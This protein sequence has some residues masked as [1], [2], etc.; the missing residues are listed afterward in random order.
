MKVREAIRRIRKGNSGENPA[1]DALIQASERQAPIKFAERAAW[2]EANA[3]LSAYGP[4]YCSRNYEFNHREELALQKFTVEYRKRQPLWHPGPKTTWR[5]YAVVAAAASVREGLRY[6][7]NLVHE[8]EPTAIAA[9]AS[10]TIDMAK[11]LNS[12]SLNESHHPKLIPI[13][14]KCLAWP[15]LKARRH[16]F[17]DNHDK[18]ISVFKSARPRF[19]G[20]TRKRGLIQQE[21]LGK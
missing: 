8:G 21:G 15:A 4:N 14:R 9:F 7:E 13:A 1:I 6:L 17:S 16:V 2:L 19:L 10:E 12:F 3:P 5:D 20:K 11:S 18:L